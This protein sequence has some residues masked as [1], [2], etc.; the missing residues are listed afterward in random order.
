MPSKLCSNVPYSVFTMS[1]LFCFFELDLI[2]MEMENLWDFHQ[3]TDS[4]NLLIG[5]TM[6]IIIVIATIRLL[7]LLGITL[8]T[9]AIVMMLLTTSERV[10]L[11]S[12]RG[13]IKEFIDYSLLSWLLT[14]LVEG[15]T[16][17]YIKEVLQNTRRLQLCSVVMSVSYY[18]TANTA[19][20][21]LQYCTYIHSHIKD[22]TDNIPVILLFGTTA[23]VEMLRIIVQG[24]FII[25][26][27]L[28]VCDGLKGLSIIAFH[29]V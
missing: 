14:I 8:D 26:T 25:Y 22:S 17:W 24:K 9:V 16:I 11:V 13:N 7:P 21:L 29:R 12:N 10:K 15:R 19:V 23:S 6:V 5:F 4:Q 28:N 1:F 27:S 2:R 3:L 20:L 18:I